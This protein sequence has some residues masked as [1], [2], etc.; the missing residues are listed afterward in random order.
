MLTKKLQAF[1]FL[2]A[3]PFIVLGQS[4]LFEYLSFL[5]E[6]EVKTIYMAFQDSQGMMWFASS[7]GAY[8]FNG[9]DFQLRSIADSGM[10]LPVT[11][12][13]EG[14]DGKIW[15]GHQNGEVSFY[16]NGRTHFLAYKGKLPTTRITGILEDNNGILW[17]STYGEG[18]FYLKNGELH[19]IAMEN[20]LSENYCYD[21]LKDDAG[22]I[23]IATD[24]GIS[25]CR[26]D[27]GSVNI[28]Q[29][30]VKDGLND[31]IVESLS[32]CKMNKAR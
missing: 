22:D 8:T 13:F 30:T 1:L 19:Q 15:F 6:K 18:V 4:P 3:F 21:I 26:F 28:R 2:F 11:F 16:E 5:P 9:Y 23:W 31:F 29:L 17:L 32:K 12:I 10:R 24:N 27:N 14:K 20:G 25:I 7:E